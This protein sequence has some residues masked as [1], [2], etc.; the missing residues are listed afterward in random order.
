LYRSMYPSLSEKI[1][2]W[3]A[4]AEVPRIAKMFRSRISPKKILV[5]AKGDKT[6]VEGVC[7]MLSMR[8]VN[9]SLLTYGNHSRLRYLFELAT[10]SSVVYVGRTE[11]QGL[12]IQEAWAMSVKTFV[13]KD[14]EFLLSEYGQ[15]LAFMGSPQENAFAPYLR[16]EDGAMWSNLEELESFL[17][18]NQPPHA[19]E[20]RSLGEQPSAP[21]SH[22]LSVAHLLRI[23]ST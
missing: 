13:Y 18:G 1:R 6:V 15:H 5:Y 16:P 7:G 9:Y 10:S 14:A 8:G 11:S 2:I 4:S 19:G 12:A 21:K 20:P 17:G 23:M 3:A 22:L